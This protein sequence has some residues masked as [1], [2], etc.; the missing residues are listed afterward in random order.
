[1]LKQNKINNNNNKKSNTWI[2]KEKTEKVGKIQPFEEKTK[3]KTNPYYCSIL[4]EILG[5]IIE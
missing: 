1:M 3:T 2:T 5:D 4:L